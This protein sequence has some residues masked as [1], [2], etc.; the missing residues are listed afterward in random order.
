MP[1]IIQNE[2]KNQNI[3]G[4]FVR[5][6]FPPCLDSNTPFFMSMHAMAIKTAPINKP[7]AL[8]N[9]YFPAQLMIIPQWY[10]VEDMHLIQ[11]KFHVFSQ[12]TLLFVLISCHH[13]YSTVSA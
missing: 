2:T 10:F 4:F 13:E 12:E 9:F 8:I 7:N 3:T 11:I 5:K 1:I 6:V